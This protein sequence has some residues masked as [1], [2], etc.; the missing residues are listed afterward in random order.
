MVQT[1]MTMFGTNAKLHKSFRDPLEQDDH[2]EIDTPELLNNED[3]Q[4]YQYL[5]DYFQ[6]DIPFG[7]FDIFTHFIKISIFIYAP[8]QGHINRANKIYAYLNKIR[9]ACIRVRTDNPDYSA[10]QYH[11]FDW[12]YSAY[13]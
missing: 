12:E 4:K 1:Y 11:K 3:T 2:P 13:G 7:I 10:L 8:Q 5:I 9:N 6:W